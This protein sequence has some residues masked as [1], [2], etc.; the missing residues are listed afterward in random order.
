MQIDDLKHLWA[1]HGANLERSL[2]INERLLQ[3]TLFRKVRAALAPFIMWRALEVAIGIA[4]I[5]AVMPVLAA[6]VAV[7]RYA[8]VAGGLAVLTAWV[9]ALC[10]YVLVQ[11]ITLDYGD[12]VMT[13]QR[14]VERIRLAEYRALK[15]AVLGG[16]VAWLPAALV[17]FEALTGIDALARV[18]LGWLIANLVFGLVCLALGH[19]LSRRYVERSDLGPRAQ[20]L[21]EALSGRGVRSAAEHLADLARFERKEPAEPATA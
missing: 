18:G 2:A 3:E 19:A 17:L 4:M 15:W 14:N 11:S 16:V 8:I 9:T 20:R 10:A 6:H 21:L 1:A 5:V 13:L 7:P 12:P